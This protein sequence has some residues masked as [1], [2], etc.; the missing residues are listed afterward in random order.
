MSGYPAM[1]HRTDL[2]HQA[3]LSKMEDVLARLK[4]LEARASAPRGKSRAKPKGKAKGK[5]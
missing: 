3:A 4:A 1:L 2:K 5:A